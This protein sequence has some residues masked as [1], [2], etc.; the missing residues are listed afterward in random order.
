MSLPTSIARDQ[1]HTYKDIDQVR[2]D[3]PNNKDD[4]SSI[5]LL[6]RI[7]AFLLIL[8]LLRSFGL[9]SAWLFALVLIGIIYL[10]EEPLW[11]R[12][13]SFPSCEDD[14]HEPS[15]PHAPCPPCPG[16]IAPEVADIPT[17]RAREPRRERN[18]HRQ[19]LTRTQPQQREIN[20]PTRNIP[21]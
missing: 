8:V 12:L 4:T 14:D 9:P 16:Y 21:N 18:L 3:I 17:I 19:V 5:S 10:I 13:F 6:Q 1:V 11:A 7:A 20:C 15:P 2:S